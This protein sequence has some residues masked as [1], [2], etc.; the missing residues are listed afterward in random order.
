MYTF[1]F[2]S[3]VVRGVEFFVGGGGGSYLW[4][5]ALRFYWVGF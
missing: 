1:V 4:L 3:F 5:W 2:E